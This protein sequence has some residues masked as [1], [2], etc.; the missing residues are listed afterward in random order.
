MS[1]M[2]KEM[3]SE[4]KEILHV[5]KKIK[6]ITRAVTHINHL[7]SSFCRRLQCV[8]VCVS[9]SSAA[10]QNHRALHEASGVSHEQGKRRRDGSEKTSCRSFGVGLSVLFCS[11]LH[12]ARKASIKRRWRR[13]TSRSLRLTRLDSRLGTAKKKKKKKKVFHFV[14]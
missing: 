9:V 5:K 2:L 14:V 11:V 8:T 12:L 4:A 1:E 3:W 10:N 13:F 7:H 6:K